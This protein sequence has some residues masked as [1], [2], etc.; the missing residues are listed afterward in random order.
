VSA[1]SEVI[2]GSAIGG[3]D[4]I[5]GSSFGGT[6]NPPVSASV[7]KPSSAPS[8]SIQVLKTLAPFFQFR[9][10]RLSFFHAFCPCSES[11]IVR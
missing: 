7:A 5:V 2:C 3:V 1:I 11:G 8:N 10:N 9:S 6:E 4:L